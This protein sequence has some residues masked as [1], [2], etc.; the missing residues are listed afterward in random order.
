HI[1]ED[2]LD[3]SRAKTGKLALNIAPIKMA[4]ALSHILEVVSTQ[5]REAQ[6][7]LNTEGMDDTGLDELVVQGDGTRIEQIVWNL[8]SNAIKF[9]PPGGSITVTLR[10]D[11]ASARLDV[12]DTG[13]GIAKSS[14]KSVFEMRS[15]EHTSELQSR[16]NLVCRLLLEKETER[17]AM[18]HAR[19]HG[20]AA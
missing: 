14:L 12:L 7:V 8:L 19:D 3:I 5:A 20:R 9:T 13:I 16:E 17:T 2:L 4:T 10:R 6:V 18:A 1:I 15:E 11:G